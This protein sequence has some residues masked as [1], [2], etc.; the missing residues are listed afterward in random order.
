MLSACGTAVK[1]HDDENCVDLGPY[2]GDCTRILSNKKRTI[3]R[4]VWEGLDGPDARFGRGCFTPEAFGH[5]KGSLLKLCQVA[6]CSQEEIRA[7]KRLES[8][9]VKATKKADLI[10][11]RLR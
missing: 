7:I 5:I 2:G 4:E 3:P 10:R 11:V 6:E 1:V 9:M 8:T